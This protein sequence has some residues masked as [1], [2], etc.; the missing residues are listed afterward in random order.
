MSGSVLPAIVAF[1][2]HAIL[3]RPSS[4]AIA[5]GEVK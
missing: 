1:M 5:E 4:A 2:L 3:T